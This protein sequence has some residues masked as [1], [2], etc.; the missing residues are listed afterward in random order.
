MKTWIKGFF[1][2]TLVFAPLLMAQVSPIHID[3]TTKLKTYGNKIITTDGKP[4]SPAVTLGDVIVMALETPLTTDKDLTPA[5]KFQHDAL[6]RK[7]YG[8]DGKLKTDVILTLDEVKLIKDRV[9]EAY[10]A[11]V[12]GAVWPLLDA[13][14]KPAGN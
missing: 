10:G 5:D 7:L 1:S 3:A 2:L 9:G 14:E 8:S 4:D 12:I 13:S 11:Q 6:A